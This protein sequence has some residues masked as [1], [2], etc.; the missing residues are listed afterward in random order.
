GQR[1]V[2]TRVNQSA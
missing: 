2:C 1:D